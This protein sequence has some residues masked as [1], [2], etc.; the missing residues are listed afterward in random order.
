MRFLV[1]QGLYA[2]GGLV[3]LAVP[4][5]DRL[6]RVPAPRADPARRRLRRL[7]RPCSSSGRR[8]TARTAGSS[9][10]RSASSRRSSRSSPSASGS[11]AVLA[12]RPPPKTMAELMKPVGLVVCA[13]AAVIVVEPDLGTTISLVAMVAGILLV[14][15]VPLRLFALAASFALGGGLLAIWMEPYRRERVFSFL[16]PWKDAEGAGFQ[17][18]QAIIGIGSGG[19]TGEGLGQGIQKV[20]FL[21][22][23]HTD[24]IFAV[25]GEELGLMGSAVVIAAFAVFAWAGFRV[26]LTCRDPFGKRLAAGIT[27]LVCAQAAVNLAAVL[28]LAPLTGIPLPFVSYGGSSL[29]VLLASVGVLLNIAVNERVVEARVR[30]RGR[31]N[32]RSRSSRARSGGGA[33]RSRSDGDVRRH[34]QTASSRGWCLRRASSSTPSPS[35][36]FRADR[37]RHSSAQRGARRPRPC[38]ASGSSRRRRPDVVLGGGG[39]VAGPMVLAARLRRIPAALTE[40]DAHLGLANRLA[41]PFARRLF[42]AYE[43]PGHDGAKVRVV[44]RPIPV[45][46]TGAIAR[47]RGA[48]AS[49][50]PPT[51]RVVAVFGALAGARSLNELAVSAWGALRAR[52]SCTS[53]AS[54][55]TTP[56]ARASSATTTSCCRR[57]TTSARRSRPPTSPCRARAEPCGSSRRRARP[58]S[59]S[60]TRTRPPTTRRSTHGT[61]SGAG[62]RCSSRTRR[63]TASRRSS[64]SCSPTRA[65]LAAMRDAMLALARPDAA[66]VDRGRA[67]RARGGAR[68]TSEPLAGRRLYF[69]GIGGSGMSAYANVARACGAEVRGWDA[70]ETIFSETLDGIEVDLGG[71]PRPPDGFEV[72]RLDRAPRPHRRHAARRVPRGARRRAALDRRHGRARQDDDRRDDRP[73][74]PRDRRRSRRGS[75]AGSCPSS[76]ATPAPAPGGSSS[77]GTSPTAL[78]SRSGPGSPWSRTSSSTTSAR[79]ARRRELAEAIDEWLID[80]PD[81]VRGWELEPV[82]FDLSIPGEHNRRNAAAARRGAR[83]NRRRPHGRRGRSRGV[84]RASTGASSAS[85]SA[86]A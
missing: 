51:R 7:R 3:L 43:I 48:S 2:V 74:A 66:E 58:R 55:T 10:V 42:L 71:E 72:D 78:P 24:M 11:C 34:T 28:G 46:H 47:V 79:T 57:P 12:R 49:D 15:G 1:K 41:A 77:R 62:E 29:L 70:H 27:T 83:T 65:R 33:S 5:A 80:V 30:D 60:R 9:S 19:V 54:G 16:D 81:V 75:S 39:F 82:S 26:A 63:S 40:A 85:A 59:S 38:T 18:V 35:P 50:S 22:E 14:S 69:V 86:A 32:G 44:G 4:V 76:A 53:A 6:P 8:S 25:V 45:A 56:S 20:N 68:V 67:R 37:A 31:R 61:S 84:S 23:A 17:N 36:A 52:R 64:T 13:F 21:P 73:R